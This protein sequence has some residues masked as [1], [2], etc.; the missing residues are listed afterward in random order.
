MLQNLSLLAS[1]HGEQPAITLTI[2]LTLALGTGATT[3][4]FTV[5]YAAL[6]AP[7]PYPHP[8]QLVYV[9]SKINGNPNGVSAGDF[10]DWVQQSHSFQK[11]AGQTDDTFNVG[12]GDRL[13]NMNGQY[14]T[15]GFYDMLDGPGQFFLGRDFLPEEGVAGKNNVVIITHKLWMYLFRTAPSRHPCGLTKEPYTVVGVLPEGQMD[16]VWSQLILPLVQAPSSYHD[17]H[18]QRRCPY[19]P[20]PAGRSHH[21]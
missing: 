19:Q 16:R 10:T 2:L 15:P 21:P 14:V 7:P 4:I 8:E 12:S 3:A 5:D 6:I 11:L 18:W 20:G 13:E 17:F 1:C 9:W